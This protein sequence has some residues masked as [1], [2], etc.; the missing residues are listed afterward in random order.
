MKLKSGLG[1]LIDMRSRLMM[2]SGHGISAERVFRQS[3]VKNYI[4]RV[5][6]LFQLQQL[7]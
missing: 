5:K 2:S 6:R 3:F 7:P 1:S 4:G